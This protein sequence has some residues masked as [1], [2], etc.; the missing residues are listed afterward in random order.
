[1]FDKPERGGGAA[2]G[3]YVGGESVD[4]V[5]GDEQDA[6]LKPRGYAEKS[7]NL[8]RECG[9][10]TRRQSAIGLQSRIL[11]L[12]NLNQGEI[13]TESITEGELRNHVGGGDR[14]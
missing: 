8:N 5:D 14:K 7:R 13:A 2:K 1:M 10:Q 11:L 4:G 12:E 3:A 9:V 6:G